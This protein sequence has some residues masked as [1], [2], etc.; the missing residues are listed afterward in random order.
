MSILCLIFRL[1]GQFQLVSACPRCHNLMAS[2]IL[3]W[4][5]PGILKIYSFAVLLS[6]PLL[7]ICQ[8]ND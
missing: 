1:Y 5:T 2:N 8:H 7:T 6:P 4:N 3:S